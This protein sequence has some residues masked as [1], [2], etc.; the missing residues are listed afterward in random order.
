MG[1]KTQHRQQ[2]SLSVRSGSVHVGALGLRG[3]R[4]CNAQCLTARVLI[5]QN[6]PSV[7]FFVCHCHYPPLAD[8]NRALVDDKGP[9]NT[10]DPIT[11]TGFRSRFC[12][13][14]HFRTTAGVKVL[15]M[16]HASIN[17]CLFQRNDRTRLSFRSRSLPA[18]G[19][20]MQA[21]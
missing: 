7:R 20:M 16:G 14:F 18:G 2:R 4:V 6:V 5:L 17:C 13:R 8:D 9:N 12:W 11:V 21:W 10:M 19:E 15:R 1:R 3:A